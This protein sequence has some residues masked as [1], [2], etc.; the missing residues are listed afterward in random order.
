[1]YVNVR[2]FSVLHD[3]EIDADYNFNAVV[4]FNYDDLDAKEFFEIE[5]QMWTNVFED[6]FADPEIYYPEI[7][8]NLENFHIIS[9][10]TE[11]PA[12]VNGMYSNSG[13]HSRLY[14]MNPS[15]NSGMSCFPPSLS[16]YSVEIPCIGFASI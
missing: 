11:S 13:S 8:D 5:Y 12:C 14:W 6:E 16:L 10:V 7:E 9:P 3:P 15:I 2:A 4:L 1:M